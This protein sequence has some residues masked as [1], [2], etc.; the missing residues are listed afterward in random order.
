MNL[1]QYTVKSQEAIQA[2]QQVAMEFG[3]QQIEPQHLLEGIF[4]VDENIS[5][6]LLKKSEADAQ[7]VRSATVRIL[8]NSRKYRAE[9]FTFRNQRIKYCLMRP[10]LLKKWVTNS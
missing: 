4:Q 3:N 1:N 9:I 5:P 8:K 2:A 10:T 6:F 7:L